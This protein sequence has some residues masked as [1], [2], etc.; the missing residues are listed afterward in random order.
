MERFRP[1]LARQEVAGVPVFVAEREVTHDI[2]GFD[3][4][5]GVLV[6][7]PRQRLVTIEQLASG[8]TRV[9]VL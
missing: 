6:S 5:R 1:F 9:I 2:V 7:A 4:P 8:S 3:L